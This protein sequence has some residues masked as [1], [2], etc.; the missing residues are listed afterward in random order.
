MAVALCQQYVFPPLLQSLAS[1][2]IMSCQ[3]VNIAGSK[4]NQYTRREDILH[5]G[6]KQCLM[7]YEQDIN[8]E[9]YH[10]GSSMDL[11]S[12]TLDEKHECMGYDT[13]FD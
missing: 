6:N 2:Y 13:G 3:S 11:V 10:N 4:H 1:N 9:A 5:G 8:E 7:L 12:R